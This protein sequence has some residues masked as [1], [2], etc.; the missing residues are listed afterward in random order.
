MCIINLTLPNGLLGV[1]ITMALVR[2]VILLAS[3]SAERTQ[4]PLDR[5]ALPS[6]CCKWENTKEKKYVQDP[7]IEDPKL[8]RKCEIISFYS[9]F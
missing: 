6:L 4:S 7:Y 5:I 3:S 2:G 9:I 8:K 1:L